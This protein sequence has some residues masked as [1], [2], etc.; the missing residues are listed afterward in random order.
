MRRLILTNTAKKDLA[1]LDKVIQKRIQTAL[2]KMMDNPESAP[3]KKLKGDPEEWS[4]RVGDWRVIM[5]FD[6]LGDIACIDRI[7]HR[8][9][10]YRKRGHRKRDR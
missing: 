8:S 4:L 2:D 3:L 5:Y 1:A 7:K 6:R 10:V 9:N